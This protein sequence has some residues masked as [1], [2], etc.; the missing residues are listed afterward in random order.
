MFGD[1]DLDDILGLSL[2]LNEAPNP[3]CHRHHH[4]HHP[5]PATRA[6]R[7]AEACTRFGCPFAHPAS[8]AADCRYGPAC[9]RPDCHFI[10][11]RRSPPPGRRPLTSR[12][13]GTTPHSALSDALAPG[14]P[15]GLGLAGVVDALVRY[16]GRHDG[17]VLAVEMAR[18]WSAHPAHRAEFVAHKLRLKQ[19]AALYPSKLRWHHGRN[20][21][22]HAIALAIP[23]VHTPTATVP[24][25]PGAGRVSSLWGH[26]E[27]GE[28]QRVRARLYRATGA[29]N[30]MAKAMK[31][32]ED[33]FEGS[34]TPGGSR[35]PTFTTIGIKGTQVAELFAMGPDSI[36]GELAGT[37]TAMTLAQCIRQLG[38]AGAIN[39]ELRA[40]LDT[41][42]EV[43]N[44]ARHVWTAPVTAADL[45]KVASAVLG[46]CRHVAAELA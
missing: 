25:V 27:R 10:H 36:A 2:S 18:F 9:A 6:C 17:R 43:G 35:A 4:L 21:G 16:L 23:P 22:E 14:I 1:L 39:P 11:P 12:A 19:L 8:R 3:H 7:L 32:I 29:A 26:V 37:T 45:P 28:W 33:N 24:G 46:V 15:S 5:M 42:R 44:H 20:S 13:S 41:L 31:V 40:E 30:T 38:H 34:T